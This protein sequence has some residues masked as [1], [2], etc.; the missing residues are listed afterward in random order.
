MRYAALLLALIVLPGLA[1]GAEGLDP[2]GFYEGDYSSWGITDAPYPYDPAAV[3]RENGQGCF[4]VGNGVIF[5]TLGVEPD[6]NTLSS[7]TGPGYQTRDENGGVQYWQKGDWPAMTAR[8]VRVTRWDEKRQ[9]A[10]FE[11]IEWKSQSIQVLRGTAMV[12]TI[13]RNDDL[14]LYGMTFACWHAPDPPHYPKPLPGAGT[15]A[16]WFVLKEEALKDP[17]AAA[18]YFLQLT[19]TGEE[20]QTY[21][22]QPDSLGV[23][24]PRNWVVARHG[25]KRL[26]TTAGWMK[27]N[28]T[29]AVLVPPD[30]ASA[31]MYYVVQTIAYP[32]DGNGWIEGASEITPEQAFLS[33][34]PLNP[35]STRNKWLDWSWHNLQ[36]STGDKRKDDLM[37]Q[38]PVIIETQRDAASGGVSPMVNYHGYWVRDSLGPIYMYLLNGRFDEVRRMLTYHRKA[39][40]KLQSCSM[41]VPLDVDVSDVKEPTGRAAVPGRQPAAGSDARPPGNSWDAIPVE[42]AE[43]PSLIVLEHYWLWKAMRFGARD[44]EA[45]EFLREA[46]PFI[47]HNLF[48]MQFDLARG[49]G[50]HGDET[51]TNGALYSTFDNGLPGQLGWPNGYIPTEFFS[52]DNTLLHRGAAK[53]LAEMAE[54]LGD[55][56]TESKSKQIGVLLDYDLEAY[57]DGYGY[58][59]AISPVTGQLWPEPFVNICFGPWSL[60]VPQTGLL[61]DMQYPIDAARLSF[62]TTG[63]Q[64]RHWTTPW[65]GFGTG[66]SLGSWLNAAR[67]NMDFA[68]C[69]GIMRELIHTAMPEGAWCEVY[70]PQG[71]PVNV[72]GRV[73]LIRPWESGINYVMLAMWLAGHYTG[74]GSGDLQRDIF[75]LLT[76]TQRVEAPTPAEPLAPETETTQAVQPADGMPE[77]PD[78][79]KL[80][81]LTR[82]N[83]YKEKL[84]L[85]VRLKMLT[86]DEIAAWDI[87]LPF[88]PED[89]R[90]ALVGADQDQ[91]K[92]R[93]PYLYLDRDVKLSDRRTFKTAEFW[94]ELEPVLADYKAAGGQVVDVNSLDIRL[95]ND[96]VVALKML[97]VLYPRTF[98]WEMDA[99]AIQKFH[100]EITKWARW[101]DQVAGD[102]LRLDLDFMLIER[103]LPPRACGPQG[104]DVYWMGFGDVEQDLRARGIPDGY[105]DSVCCFWAWDRDAPSLPGGRKAAQAYGGGAQG[106]G[107]D[108]TFLGPPGRTSYFGAAALKS[109]PDTIGRVGLH[110]YLHS[111]DAMF[112][113]AGHDDLFFSSDDMEMHMPQLLKERPGSFRRYGYDDKAMLELADK[114]SRGE[115]GF[116][117]RTQ[118]VYY[119]WCLERTPKQDFAKLLTRYGRREK[120][121]PRRYLYSSFILPEG[122]VP[123]QMAFEDTPGLKRITIKDVDKQD[124]FVHWRSEAWYGTLASPYSLPVRFF[125][126][127]EI[128][129]PDLAELVLGQGRP[130]L[131]LHL[132]DTGSGAGLPGAKVTAKLGD[133]QVELADLGGGDYSAPLPAGLTEGVGVT[134]SASLPGYVISDNLSDLA[135]KPVWTA[136]AQLR[137]YEHGGAPSETPFHPGV[138]LNLEGPPGRYTAR[139][140]YHQD[141]NSIEQFL[142]RDG[143]MQPAQD[144]ST[145]LALTPGQQS[146][147]ELDPHLWDTLHYATGT[148][149]IDYAAPDGAT[150]SFT[151]TLPAELG[152]PTIVNGLDPAKLPD[153]IPQALPIT[154][155][156]DGDLAEWP[157]PPSLALTPSNGHVFN[158]SF[159]G[160]DDG[161]LELYIGYDSE[162]LYLAG[163]VRDDLLVHGDMW[164]CDRINLCFDAR[165]DTTRATYPKGATGFEGWAA[166]DY[167]VFLCPFPNPGIANLVNGA[168]S[169]RLGGEIPQGGKNA[170]FGPV[171]GAEA[172]AREVPGGYVF[173]WALPLKALP[174]LKAQAGTFAGFSL[175]LSDYD[176][177]QNEMMYVTDWTGPGGISWNFWDCGL[178]YFR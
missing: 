130:E 120:L 129:T 144:Y 111:I 12:R 125:K 112:S 33:S 131:K 76:S 151:Q 58:A 86:V 91:P 115:A 113:M 80:L 45:D 43:V 24:L 171:A 114:S 152:L 41:L 81:V 57:F 92:L 44:K 165:L 27:P 147:V 140:S 96:E 78:V 26:A 15:L 71:N 128:G 105:Y 61:L 107:L 29:G 116:P 176:E 118:L 162:K 3:S 18:N 95:A 68:A 155:Q 39:C 142:A 106:P 90:N 124:S 174:Y 37:A 50:F 149:R 94:R 136:T 158:G 73:N 13:L 60:G 146:Y 17:A 34:E 79:T 87:G 100:S 22:L 163:Q 97:I 53:A 133:Q 46:W 48:A 178:L 103:R 177:G 83:A 6:F 5:A 52:Y 63:G 49:V 156:L 7:L 89:L 137:H 69:D 21:R 175:F 117:W 122:F 150:G 56:E 66:H 143:L 77:L 42:H 135:I 4:P 14:T 19:G 99:P 65:S 172:A 51:Y 72:Y 25:S 59:P 38:L 166:D 75:G 64:L 8:L 47:T 35:D 28:P 10:A 30:R 153:Y 167:W 62:P 138:A 121:E 74:P 145:E 161:S 164:G 54:V 36:F 16:R 9:P 11:P 139:L 159:S 93:V 119:Q 102:K 123:V 88:M 70:D 31:G 2:F 40:W 141:L 23:S 84:K 104:G 32:A 132:R 173:E 1:Y 67:M 134:Y 85:D 148:L 20:W 98:T 109:H 169:M 126:E 55:D 101:Y 170:Y 127:A 168:L 154:P 110:E 160:G 157:G 82:D 108:M